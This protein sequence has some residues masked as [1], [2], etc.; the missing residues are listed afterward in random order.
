MQK[1]NILIPI[2]ILFILPIYSDTDSN[3]DTFSEGSRSISFYG[4]AV[5]RLAHLRPRFVTITAK[6]TYYILERMAVKV[7]NAKRRSSIG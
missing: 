7:I 2:L 4:Q 6:L 5:N 3:I 1:N